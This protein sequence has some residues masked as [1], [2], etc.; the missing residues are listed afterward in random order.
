MLT[1]MTSAAPGPAQAA[2]AYPGKSIRIVCPFPPGGCGRN[3]APAGTKADGAVG[4]G[5]PDVPA[6]AAS[7]VPG[8]EALQ[9]YGVLL[10]AGTP[11][12]IVAR[13][14]EAIQAILELPEVK[15]QLASEGGEVVGGTP[16]EFASYMEREIAKWTNVVKAA[17]IK[18]E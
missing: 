15:E 7:G 5:L 12:A 6:I 8:Y 4:S 11:G 17:G 3:V 13:L 10:P 9:W 14:N 1:G 2:D 16:K 18:A